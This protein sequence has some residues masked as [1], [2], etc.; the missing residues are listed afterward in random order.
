MI[1]ANVLVDASENHRFLETVCNRIH[2]W[3]D[4]I[5][6]ATVTPNSVLAAHGKVTHVS[7]ENFYRDA[8]EG[9]R[10]MAQEGDTIGQITN[11][12]IVFDYEPMRRVSKQFPQHLLYYNQY[13]MYDQFHF[14]DDVNLGPSLMPVLFPF[15]DEP[16]GTEQ[17]PEMPAYVGK[18]SKMLIPLGDV[19]D[20]SML[21]EKDSRH[22]RWMRGG[23]VHV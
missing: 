2:S 3:A 15:K 5:H 13:L 1:L 14:Y 12:Q 19:L 10:E 9:L 7:E 21:G 17:I 22:S 23:L 8:W 4:E 6:F 20:Y 18:L 11:T 16:Y